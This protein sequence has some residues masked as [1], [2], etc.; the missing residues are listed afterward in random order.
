MTAATDF[1]ILVDE[2]DRPLG[3]MEKME[4]HRQGRLHRAFSILLFNDAGELLLQRRAFSKYHCGGLWTNTCCSHPRPGESVADAADRRLR[5]EMGI[6]CALAPSF[7]FIYRARFDNGL[8]EH[9]F[10]H[11]LEGRFTGTP[12]VDPAEVAEWKY[13]SPEALK[14]SIAAHPE[15]YTPWFRL[16]VAKIF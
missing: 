10:D 13:M 8:T 5:E 7:D 12:A 1:V 2:N 3:S 9:E 11:V 15:T 6:E 4:A 14:T 16:I